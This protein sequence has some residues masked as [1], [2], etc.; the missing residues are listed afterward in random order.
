MC[1][2]LLRFLW[3]QIKTA[4]FPDLTSFR[5]IASCLFLQNKN[6]GLLRELP[7]TSETINVFVQPSLGGFPSVTNCNKLSHQQAVHIPSLFAST[8]DV[9]DLCQPYSRLVEVENQSGSKVH[10]KSAYPVGLTEK[11]HWFGTGQASQPPSRKVQRHTILDWF[12]PLHICPNIEVTSATR[13][14]RLEL[15]F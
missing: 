14:E 5:R 8:K 13:S 1:A 15:C 9:L 6:H 4:L 2:W 3:P 12:Q 11:R 7:A 10:S